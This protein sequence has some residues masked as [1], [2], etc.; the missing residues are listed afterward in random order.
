MMHRACLAVT[1]AVLLLAFAR[2]QDRPLSRE[3]VALDEAF[4]AAVE[5]A[6]PSVACV[7][8]SR[9]DLYR[10]LFGDVPPADEPGKLGAYNPEKATSRNHISDA[11]QTTA[12]R[13]HL[14]DPANVPEA[15]GSG[16]VIDAKGLILTNYHVVRDAAKLYVRLPG[17]KG[18]YANIYAADPRSDL[19]VLELLFDEGRFPLRA[20]KLGD[21]GQVK[22]GQLVLSLAHPYAAGARDGSASAAWGI[23][24]NLRRR[25]PFPANLDRYEA[26]RRATLHH[27]GTLIQ[28]DARL[29]LGCSGGALL[30]LKGEMIGLT[31]ALAALSGSE[32]AGGYAVPMDTGTVRII[33]Q[34]LKQGEEVEYGFL[35]ITPGER[36]TRFV[37]VGIENVGDGSPAWQ[38]GLRPGHTITAIDGTPLRENDDLFL[39]VGMRLAGSVVKIKAVT[40]NGPRDFTVTLAKYY[41]PGKI[42]AANRPPAARGLRVDYVSVLLQKQTATFMPRNFVQPATRGGVMISEVLPGSAAER[43]RLQPNEVI[44][45][46]NDRT[47][48][49]PAEFYRAVADA[50]RRG[51]TAT[52]VELT[53]ARPDWQ[54]QTDKVILP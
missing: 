52:P 11:D 1:A 39:H 45:H 5:A 51:G 14:G 12:R 10:K 50:D 42:I 37:G 26:Y 40:E 13:L 47:V 30:N 15:F 3:I 23:V 2:A 41:V 20:I 29:N 33:E 27:Y 36:P 25:A 8:V 21:G 34:K 49:S 35:G 6:E 38:A 4:Q 18:S 28:T 43:A 32:T 9:S 44:T 17:G 7:L 46:V 31:T 54:K 16:A 53:I 48:N 22:K 24:S 19:A